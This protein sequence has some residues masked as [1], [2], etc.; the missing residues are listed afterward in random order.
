ALLVALAR[1]HDDVARLRALERPGDRAPTIDLDLRLAHHA[2]QHLVDD[3]AWILAARVVGRHD[4]RIGERRSDSAHERPLLPVAFAAAAEDA[5]QPARAERAGLAKHALE[6]VG[7]VRVVD[8]PRERLAL[9]DRLEAAGDAGEALYPGG[10]R[11][12]IQLQQAGNGNRGD[13]VRDVEPPPEPR[14]ELEPTGPKPR[15]ARE[16]L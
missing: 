13:G 6:R 9:V 10:D 12:V 15:S 7:L 16:E 4:R 14:A 3:R 11:E 1:D 2:R 8:E 5:D